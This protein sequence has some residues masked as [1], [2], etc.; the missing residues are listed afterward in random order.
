MRCG[1]F[2]WGLLKGLIGAT[3]IKVAFETFL[4]SAQGSP[5]DS[6]LISGLVTSGLFAFGGILVLI[7]ALKSIREGLDI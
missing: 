7:W 1:Q 3:M 5:S 2:L 6:V 4:R